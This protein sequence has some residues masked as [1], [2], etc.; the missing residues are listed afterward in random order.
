M[1]KLSFFEW[2]KMVKSK[3]TWIVFLLSI[4][5]V[6][7]IYFLHLQNTKNVERAVINQYDFLIDLYTDDVEYWKEEKEEALVAKDE[8][9]IEEATMMEEHAYHMS[10]TNILMKQSYLE[11]DWK[12][13]YQYELENLEPFVNPLPGEVAYYN[14]EGQA[15]TDFTLRASY[16]EINYKKDHNIQP[17]TQDTTVGMLFPTAYDEFEG[18]TLDLWQKT[19]KR[20]GKQGLY[21]AY[22][23]I[24]KMY[25]PIIILL[26]CFI[27]GNTISIETRTKH[28]HLSFYKVLPIHQTKLFLSKFITG[29]LG[30][31]IFVGIMLT[32][33]MFVGAMMHGW[34][35][36]DYPILVYDGYTTE[37]MQT[38]AVEN[39]F[40]FITLKKYLFNTIILSI[41]IS[42]LIY[43]I[44]FFISQFSKEPIFNVVIV[45][46]LS[47]V[48]AKQF[49]P[50]NPFSYLDTDKVMTHEIQLQTWNA[51][52]TLITGISL[53]V[54]LAFIF[55]I[56]N[57]IAFRYRTN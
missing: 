44:Y 26:G 46:V 36:P 48:A 21:F 8:D 32:I 3:T 52:F 39:S 38:N 42:L 19:R 20:Y 11:E 1:M 37:H 14:F 17:F 50:F 24:Q 29:Y 45:G 35:N 5:A 23:L 6:I 15:V 57:Y 10:E 30:V 31:L 25:I 51:G 12:V 13:I 40:H 34:G 33:P 2:K 54:S 43:S 27:F 9:L 47:Y 49:Q 53:N 16:E 41:S 55:L 22:Q 56:L 28:K 4:V 7:G 18:R